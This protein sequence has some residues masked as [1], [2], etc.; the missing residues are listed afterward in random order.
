M[1]TCSSTC[2]HCEDAS[3]ATRP[4]DERRSS[5]LSAEAIS[6]Q[7]REQQNRL[8]LQLA[9][10]G[11]PPPT[12]AAWRA[13]PP[14]RG[15]LARWPRGACRQPAEG[16]ELAALRS[17][18]AAGRRACGMAPSGSWGSRGRGSAGR[19]GVAG[20][21]RREPSA[22]GAPAALGHRERQRRAAGCAS[23][24]RRPS[25]APAPA[26]AAEGMRCALDEL[27]MRPAGAARGAFWP[28]NEG[29]SI[30]KPGPR[31]WGRAPPAPSSASHGRQRG[32]R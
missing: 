5:C 17:A 10:A 2:A 8:A 20:S 12:P 13:R 15:R 28:G 18:G 9:T 11:A 25:A 32:Q 1:P 26:G 6:T 21:L 22:R 24:E 19:G 4:A 30:G 14:G 31:A 3:L 29:G 7:L 23:T 16:S 27:G